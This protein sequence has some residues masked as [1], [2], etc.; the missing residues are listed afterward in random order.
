ML[1]HY[2]LLKVWEGNNTLLPCTPYELNFLIDCNYKAPNDYHH[3]AL[4]SRQFGLK[5]EISSFNNGNIT[6]LHEY[7]EFMFFYKYKMVGVDNSF[8][9][10]L[11]S[12]KLSA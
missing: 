8:C 7:A 1:D 5:N 9:I 4:E 6:E 11:F 10:G 12:D 2:G 3:V